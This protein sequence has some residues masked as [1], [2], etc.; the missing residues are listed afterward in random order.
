MQLF[1]VDSFAVDDSYCQNCCMF[2]SY[3]ALSIIIVFA[4]II[5][6][7]THTHKHIHTTLSGSHIQTQTHTYFNGLFDACQEFTAILHLHLCMCVNVLAESDICS[8]SMSVCTFNLQL[9]ISLCVCVC[10]VANVSEK[11]KGIV[12]RT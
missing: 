8:L 9:C 7:H 10:F 3:H 12:R 2:S 1:L 11:R 6:T 4:Q 5:Y